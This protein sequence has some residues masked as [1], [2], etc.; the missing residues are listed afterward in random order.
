[1]S[2]RRN[3]GGSNQNDLNRGAGGQYIYLWMQK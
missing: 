3:I 2:Q 1:V